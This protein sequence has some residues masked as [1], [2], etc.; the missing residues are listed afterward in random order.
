[1]ADYA[2]YVQCQ[3]MSENNNIKTYATLNKVSHANYT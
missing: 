2:I 3:V 1:M